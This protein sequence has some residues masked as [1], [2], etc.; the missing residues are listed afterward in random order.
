MSVYGALA[1]HFFLAPV[2]SARNVAKCACTRRDS[3]RGAAVVTLVLGTIGWYEN[4]SPGDR[5][6]GE[7]PPK[8]VAPSYYH[9]TKP[10]QCRRAQQ[11]SP[12]QHHTVQ[13][14]SAQIRA[15][16]M[17]DFAFRYET[18]TGYW[19]AALTRMNIRRNNV[20]RRM[21]GVPR[22]RQRPGA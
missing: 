12:G 11:S 10:D 1:T 14:G 22:F 13:T 3:M 5:L 8:S 19:R 7:Q 2:M 21:Y 15:Q 16:F 6:S 20:Q 17:N 9:P 18:E 4:K